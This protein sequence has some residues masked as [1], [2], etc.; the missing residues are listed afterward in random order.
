MIVPRHWAEGRVRHRSAERQVTVRRFG[1]SDSSLAE[2]QAMADARAAEALQR[3][4]S[5]EKLP[6]RE[7]KVPYNGAQ[8]VPIR[9]EIVSRHGA[10]IVTRNSYGA[11]CLN[12][13]DV[14]FADIDF[15]N[16]PSLRFSFAVFGVLL[17]LAI[18][19]GWASHS[20]GLGIGLAILSM[21]V[22][23][24]VSG[25][26]FQ[27]AS[28]SSGGA[29]R[30]ARG[31]IDAF[32]QHH[33]EWNLRLYRT[34]AGIRV[35]ATHRTFDANEPAVAECFRALHTDP[36]YIAMCLNQQCFRA[37]VSAKP[38]RIGIGAHMRPRPG[39]WPVAPERLAVRDA[40]IAAYE[41]AAASFAACSLLESVGSGAVHPDVLPVQE[42]HDRLAAATTGLPIA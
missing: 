26:L 9:E 7:P 33:P 29:E 13:P 35:L 42:L 3:L 8:G 23:R 32:L 19:A 40:W 18:G 10:I 1:W 39:V 31:R 15:E 14:L 22:A 24:G 41:A 21:F 30:V 36:V 34:P 38:W 4:L 28:K 20:R 16:E 12:T 27:A 6:R 5:G 11:R 2:A 25:L 17:L 37:R